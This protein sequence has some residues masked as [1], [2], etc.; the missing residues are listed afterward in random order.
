MTHLNVR[1][2]KIINKQ[3][4]WVPYPSNIITLWYL[5]N[6]CSTAIT[7]LLPSIIWTKYTLKQD[8]NIL[9][10]ESK[11]DEAGVPYP[12]HIIM[13][14]YLR[15]IHLTAIKN[16]LP[17]TIWT[18]YT[19]KQD[20]NIFKLE[21]LSNH[22]YQVLVPILHWVTKVIIHTQYTY[23]HNTHIHT[24][25]ICSYTRTH[26]DT[27]T[28]THTHGC[29]N[30]TSL[31]IIEIYRQRVQDLQWKDLSI[32][33]HCF[34]NYSCLNMVFSTFRFTDLHKNWTVA[35]N[36]Q[37]QTALPC[38]RRNQKS[39]K[40]FI[41]K[42]VQSVLPSFYASSKISRLLASNRPI[43]IFHSRWR[44]LHPLLPC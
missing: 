14:L 15:N 31:Q 21:S 25:Y 40:Q 28:Q 33:N 26:A 30:A 16:L 20:P 35:C 43:F 38:Q 34:T 5:R 12:S 24:I 44:L 17:S 29:S 23:T 41:S 1:A 9:K 2:C 32:I 22:T 19:L 3:W 11:S 13:L 10:L 7:N 36:F 6:I 18:K 4:S 42:H 39:L 27:H 8:P 37:Y